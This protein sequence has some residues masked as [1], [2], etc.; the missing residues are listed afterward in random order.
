MASSNMVDAFATGMSGMGTPVTRAEAYAKK[1]D[2]DLALKKIQAQTAAGLPESEAKVLAMKN[3]QLLDE[4]IKQTTFDAFRAWNA[5][6]DP[7]HLNNVLKN[8]IVKEHFPHV[9]RVD[10][11]DPVKDR[12]LFLKAANGDTS[13]LDHP[14][15]NP[16]F[17][18]RFVK[19]TH[20]D[21]TQELMDVPTI[22][23]ATGYTQYASDEELKRLETLHKIQGKQDSR[24][25]LD[26]DSERAGKIRADIAA[27]KEISWQDKEFMKGW[28]Q[29]LAGTK[30]G[31]IDV[32]HE[33]EQ[34]MLA[35]IG[36]DAAFQKLNFGDRQDRNKVRPY[37][38]RME[39]AGGLNLDRQT[40][41]LITQ[42]NHLMALGK[43]V[44]NLTPEE[45][46]LMDSLIY[47]LTKYVPGTLTESDL[48][49]LQAA[50]GY[51]AFQNELRKVL[52]GSVLTPGEIEH[53]NSAYG[54]LKQQ[55]PVV[56]SQFKTMLSGLKSDIES[57]MD[58]NNP[59]VA[60][61]RLGGSK[62]EID[63]MLENID[64]V[65]KGQM[66]TAETKADIMKKHAE[67]AAKAKGESTPT[68]TPAA[69][70]DNTEKLKNIF[71][72]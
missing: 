52:Y 63:T 47:K 9:S 53:F 38:E 65:L 21:G 70:G 54:T 62:E 18:K 22:Q 40:R 49:K 10:A 35:H 31:Q 16:E 29:R 46:G 48:T 7:R 19:I 28:T 24:T 33:A 39:Q 72:G 15:T 1:A 69:P 13:I 68:P 17:F 12:K 41:T 3:Q 44:K 57:I 43:P 58:L 66:S 71:G 4:N 61:Y 56:M 37:I 30:P 8:P 50:S 59:Y 36:G 42:V 11:A 23:A 14:D 26:R 34:E 67:A 55:F 5:D 32:A 27:G 51:A 6:F 25:Q 64:T 20:T 60:E 2:A 45:T